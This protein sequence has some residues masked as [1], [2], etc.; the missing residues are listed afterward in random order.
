MTFLGSWS[1]WSPLSLPI[2]SQRSPTAR[3]AKRRLD[4]LSW[5]T[6]GSDGLLLLQ[7]LRE[8]VEAG[9]HVAMR[10]GRGA[11]PPAWSFFLSRAG[12]FLV[13]GNRG[14]PVFLFL[15]GESETPLAKWGACR[16]SSWS[17]RT[18]R[19]LEERQTHLRKAGPL[20][21]GLR[22]NEF[23]LATSFFEPCH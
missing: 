12:V 23:T 8:S 18:L 11:C 20:L 10:E 1:Y 2:R 21:N 3:R 15:R 6:A 17:C 19:T 5:G 13:S 4:R 9:G 7:Q 14:P 22:K 16:G